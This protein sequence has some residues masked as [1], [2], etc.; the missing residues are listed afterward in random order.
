MTWI[1]W[2]KVVWAEW[3]MFVCSVFFSS[4][5]GMHVEEFQ[6]TKLKAHLSN[7]SCFLFF[8]CLNCL[9]LHKTTWREYFDAKFLEKRE[10]CLCAPFFFLIFSSPRSWRAGHLLQKRTTSSS[11]TQKTRLTF[12]KLKM[13][14]IFFNKQS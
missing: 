12:Q 11:Q 1:F 10:R 13:K 4:M 3:E 2:C 8:C 14:I 7:T 5:F 9:F 6:T